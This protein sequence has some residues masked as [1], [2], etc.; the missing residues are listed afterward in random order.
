MSWS[1]THL[2]DLAAHDYEAFVAL[3]DD[4][5]TDVEIVLVAIEA[6]RHCGNRYRNILLSLLH[7]AESEVRTDA[8]YALAEMLWLPE[9]L[10][11]FTLLDDKDAR[12]S[13]AARDVFY[14][15]CL[16]E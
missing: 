4:T 16:E 14:S 11:I 6:A 1:F 9:T 8:I 5:Q 3:L 7:S 15:L 2:R 13:S 10:P 12:V